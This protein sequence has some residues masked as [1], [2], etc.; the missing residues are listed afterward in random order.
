MVQT[1][2]QYHRWVDERG[3]DYH[4]SQS[5]CSS[6]ASQ[7]SAHD[8]FTFSQHSDHP[9]EFPSYSPNDHC[10]RHRKPDEDEYSEQVVSYHRRKPKH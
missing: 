8:S 4:T 10:K 6:C 9:T 7:A 1:R 3:E 5:Q 2:R